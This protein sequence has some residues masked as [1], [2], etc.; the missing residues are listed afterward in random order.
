MCLQTLKRESAQFAHQ[1]EVQKR[2]TQKMS[3][4]PQRYI[5]SPELMS[6]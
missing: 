3:V 1:Q 5:A 2:K 6:N 4:L